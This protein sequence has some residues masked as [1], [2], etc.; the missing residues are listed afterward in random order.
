MTL[1]YQSGEEIRKGD[2]VLYFG[3]PGEIEFVVDSL[4]GDPAMDWYFK[5]CG[6]GVM[7]LEPKH[8]GSVYVHAN[9]EDLAF[10]R[11]VFVSRSLDPDH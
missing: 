6:P 8:F 11:L 9:D 10:V 7:V 2:R 5:E 1:K 3:E 4:V